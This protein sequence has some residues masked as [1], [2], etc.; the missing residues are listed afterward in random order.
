MEAAFQQ[1]F[2]SAL[3]DVLF[4]RVTDVFVIELKKIKN[5]D[6]AVQ[7][8]QITIL[9]AQ[10]FLMKIDLSQFQG[11]DMLIQVLKKRVVTLTTLG[12]DADDVMDEIALM[13]AK[14]CS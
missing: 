13:I 5:V 14:R 3:L 11:N 9:E 1:G 7:K 4:S 10:E 2:A 12:Y 6:E 8:L